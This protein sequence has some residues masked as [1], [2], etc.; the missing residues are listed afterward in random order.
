MNSLGAHFNDYS[1][2]F[3]YGIVMLPTLLVNYIYY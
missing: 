1:D 2:I 3:E